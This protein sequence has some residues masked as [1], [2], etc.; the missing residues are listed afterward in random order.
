MRYACKRAV[1]LCALLASACGGGEPEPVEESSESAATSGGEAPSEQPQGM[2]VEGILGKIPESRIEDTMS[3]KLPAFQRCFFDGMG[4][5]ELLA[6][7]FKFY[8][9]V[10]L[11]G[12]VEYV[13]PRGSSVGH[14]PTEQC[15]LDIAKRTRFPKPQGGGAA[16]F[17]WGFEIESPGGV[18]P[19][20]SWNEERVFE[21]VR[22]GRPSLDACE[23]GDARYTVTIYVAP[24]GTVLSAGAAA[25]SQA[26]ADKIDCVLAAVK[27]WPMPDPGSYPAKVSFGL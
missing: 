9:R 4:E 11:D 20:V 6:G 10:G 22:A 25:D 19:P 7:H 3:G 26:A 23:L 2:Q 21:A 15:L 17:V 16:E 12:R 1:L 8:F 18:R 24:G 13:H 14:R 27:S 5:V